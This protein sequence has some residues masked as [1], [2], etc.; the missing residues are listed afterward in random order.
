[1]GHG[2]CVTKY[3]VLKEEIETKHFEEARSW[4]KPVRN[5]NTGATPPKT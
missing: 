4:M 1:M 3:G 5:P 2:V